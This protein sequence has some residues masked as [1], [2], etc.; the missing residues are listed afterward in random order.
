[1]AVAAGRWPFNTGAAAQLTDKTFLAT[2]SD[3]ITITTL[4]VLT[5][6]TQA[7]FVTRWW[8]A[9]VGSETFNGVGTGTAHGASTTTSIGRTVFAGFVSV[10][11]AVATVGL[12]ALIVLAEETCFTAVLEV[13]AISASTVLVTVTS[14][15]VVARWW[16]GTGGLAFNGVVVAA[17][18]LA[19]G[20]ASVIGT[21][22]AVFPG[23]HLAVATEIGA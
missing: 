7:V 17:T 18:H 3:P 12:G 1:M 5:V 19:T 9:N 15:I 21:V 4:T 6:F 2:V 11:L 20:T 13:V 10:E 14:T 16:D 8:C 22:V 23:I